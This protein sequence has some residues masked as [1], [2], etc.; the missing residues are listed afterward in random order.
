LSEWQ[1]GDAQ[2]IVTAG[3]LPKRSSLSKLFE[4]SKTAY[5]AAIYDDPPGRAEIEDLLK[6]AGIT[7]VDRAAMVD[8]EALARSLSAGISGRPSTS[9]ASTSAATPA[10]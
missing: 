3:V 7:D 9:S 6:G 4:G 2:I 1:P 8:L 10:P 5:V